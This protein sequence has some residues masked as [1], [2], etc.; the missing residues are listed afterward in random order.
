MVADSSSQSLQSHRE[1]RSLQC[2]R[3]GEFGVECLVQSRE[4]A[5]DP[6][7][8]P[9]RRLPCDDAFE[10]ATGCDRRL[11]GLEAVRAVCRVCVKQRG[12]TRRARGHPPRVSVTPRADELRTARVA[13]RRDE[14]GDVRPLGA[15]HLG[16]IL[17]AL[18]APRGPHGQR[19]FDPSPRRGLFHRPSCHTGLAPQTRAES[20]QRAGILMLGEPH[21]IH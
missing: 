3:R 14:C 15:L 21:H 4:R 2:R 12:D 1:R 20:Q 16:A 5:R 9:T 19:R 11:S 7:Q 13:Q 17:R 18:C 10:Y 6:A 8:Q